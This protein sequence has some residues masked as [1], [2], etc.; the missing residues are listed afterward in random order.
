MAAKEEGQVIDVHTKE[1]FER[2]FSREKIM[3]I[4]FTAPW[5][6]P[7]R[8]IAP[9]F[10]ELAKEFPEDIAEAYNVE[11]MPTFLFFKEGEKVDIRK[12]W[13]RLLETL[14][15]ELNVDYTHSK[16]KEQQ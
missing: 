9:L 15:R 2:R 5:C 4:M 10:A 13:S 12:G 3:V 1:E 11:A 14:G 6:E 16:D 7:G 8:D